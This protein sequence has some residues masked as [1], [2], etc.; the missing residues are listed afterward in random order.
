[1]SWFSENIGTLIVLLILAA[2]VVLIIRSMRRDKAAGKSFC[3]AGCAHC[4]MR[5]KCHGGK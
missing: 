3:G 1:M 5:G 2:V 4:A